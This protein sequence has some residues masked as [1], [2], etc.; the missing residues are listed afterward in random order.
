MKKAYIKPQM[1]QELVQVE[2]IM[3]DSSPSLS[4]TSANQDAG[5]DG[6]RRYA[7]EDNFTVADIW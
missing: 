7:D 3:L 4:A 5:M 1:E 6:K 2:S